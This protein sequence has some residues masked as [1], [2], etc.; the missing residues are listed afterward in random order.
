[1][2]DE[3]LVNEWIIAN[4]ELD[5]PACAIG[6]KRGERDA[7]C[8]GLAAICNSRRKGILRL[9]DRAYQVHARQH[10]IRGALWH[11]SAKGRGKVEILLAP[12]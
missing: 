8:A 6:A 7:V 11:T 2:S 9:F 10:A 5:C 1:V 12:M 4:L 3:L